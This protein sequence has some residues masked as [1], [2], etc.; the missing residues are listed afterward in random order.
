MDDTRS[1]SVWQDRFD[2]LALLAVTGAIVAVASVGLGAYAQ[3]QTTLGFVG[4]DLDLTFVLRQAG[5]AINP[6]VGG[7]L[8]AAFLLVVEGPGDRLGRIGR[9]VL[10]ATVATGLIFAVGAAATA[11]DRVLSTSSTTV[12]VELVAG[13]QGSNLAR[14]ADALPSAVVAAVCGF[15]AWCAWGF[16]APEGAEP[17]QD[18]VDPSGEELDDGAPAT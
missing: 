2:V 11:V 5:R 14:V 17:H 3:Q 15:L 1:E 7:L 4:A 6:L 8:V 9:V 12:N 13:P 16:L 18:G 10:Y